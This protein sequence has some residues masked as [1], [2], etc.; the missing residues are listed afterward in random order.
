MVSSF[1]IVG[2]VV[3]LPVKTTLLDLLG[4]AIIHIVCVLIFAIVLKR[5]GAGFI[6]AFTLHMTIPWKSFLIW[7]F[8]VMAAAYAMEYSYAWACEA[9]GFG[10]GSQA[11]DSQFNASN[12][13]YFDL[14]LNSLLG[15]LILPFLEELIFRGIVYQSLRTKICSW[16]AIPLSAAIFSAS[17]V[18][19][20]SFLPLFGVGCALA[21]TFE[22]K[23]TLWLPIA[24][25]CSNNMLSIAWTML[26]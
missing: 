17:H 14:A 19:V 10:Y 11:V 20:F 9:L 25:H 2:F 13:K 16:Q 15:M 4:M 7:C 8:A 24:I 21:Y 23:R 1:I 3:L 26:A 18:D 22:K 5:R 6:N 12:V